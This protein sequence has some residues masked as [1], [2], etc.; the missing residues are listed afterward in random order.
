MCKCFVQQAGGSEVLV[1]SALKKNTHLLSV[2]GNTDDGIF[3]SLIAQSA[4]R[5]GCYI[6]WASIEYSHHEFTLSK[7]SKGMKILFI[8]KE[9]RKT[10]PLCQMQLWPEAACSRSF[11]QYGLCSWISGSSRG[12]V[13]NSGTNFLLYLVSIWFFQGPSCGANRLNIETETQISFWLLEK[14]LEFGGQKWKWIW[15]Q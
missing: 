8:G 1:L 11:C 10:L 5:D 14:I 7:A 3:L 6:L 9:R 2:A 13:F 15:P 12:N 4:C